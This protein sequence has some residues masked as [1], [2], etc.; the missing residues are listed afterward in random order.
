MLSSISSS[1]S[2]TRSWYW[3]WLFIAVICVASLGGYE[4]FLKGRGFIPSIEQNMNLWSWYR[5]KIQNKKEALVIVGTSRSQLDINIPY[6]KK[7]LGNHDVTQL[8]INGRYPLATLKAIA[9]DKNFIGTLIV[10]FNAQ[11]L[12]TRYLDMQGEYNQ[13]YANQSSFNKSFDAYLSAFL[14]SKLRFLHPLLGIQELV[15]FYDANEGFQDVY[16][17]TA[18]L[19]QS[20]SAD[21]TR[22]DRVALLSHFVHQKE[23]NYKSDPPTEPQVWEQ[24]IALIQAYF[25]AI[26]N[27]GGNVI[28]VR[29]PTD[30]GHWQLDEKFYP[31]KSYW[32]L[33]GR[34]SNVAT[35][36]FNDVKGLN[37]ID[38]PDSSHVDQRNTVEFT[39]ILFSHLINSGDMN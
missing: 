25:S 4:F 35:L 22:T 31:R 24:N 17:T 39:E 1:R 5:G 13:Y 34:K 37:K 15:E 32:D 3:S 2:N 26:K 33:I 38:L 8:S 28:L 20:V 19:D 9:G 18:N 27:R 12:E 21:F 10:S 14:Q 29:F 7:K 23:E 11:A 6:L 36:H 16:Y 30:K